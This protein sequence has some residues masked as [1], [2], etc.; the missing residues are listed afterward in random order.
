MASESEMKAAIEKHVT[1]YSAWTIGVTDDPDRRKTEHGDPAAWMQWKAD[2]EVAARNV[3]KYFLD[4]GMKG[5]GG[6]G[7][8]ADYV[9]IF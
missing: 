1:L 5:G 2:S 9:Y 3:E 7:G 8:K 6:G 4:K